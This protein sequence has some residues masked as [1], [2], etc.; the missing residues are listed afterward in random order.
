[1]ATPEDSKSI[2]IP[3][4]VMALAAAGG[5]AAIKTGVITNPFQPA[6][7]TAAT[8]QSAAP[9]STAPAPKTAPTQGTVPAQ[10]NKPAAVKPKV[11]KATPAVC[12]ECGVV[13]SIESFT[14]KGEASGGGAVAGGVVGGIVGHQIGKGRGKDLATIAGAVGG[15]IAGH[16]IEKNVKKVTRYR[17]A[18]RMDDGTQQVLTLN[19]ANN[20]AV[21]DKVKI[22]DGTL[23]RN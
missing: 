20:V 10:V 12:R 18:L 4:V 21:G 22:V 17:I 11:A 7:E 14:E 23:V 1:M 3:I 15:A 8:V 19:A 5:V 9:T 6:E 2:L 13:E 16:E